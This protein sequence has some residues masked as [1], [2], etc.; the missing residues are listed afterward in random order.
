[1]N[2]S[3][4][5]TQIAT[6]KIARARLLDDEYYNR[7]LGVL[8]S[9]DAVEKTDSYK[10]RHQRAEARENAKW[11]LGIMRQKAYREYMTQKKS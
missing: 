2:A 1:M 7:L 3:H 9:E 10:N 11:W 5:Q 4:I 8:T 6:G